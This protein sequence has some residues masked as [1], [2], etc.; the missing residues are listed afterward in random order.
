MSPSTILP[1]DWAPMFRA[2]TAANAQY[3]FHTVAGR[4]VILSFLGS[5]GEP[6]MAQAA[7]HVRERHRAWLD[8]EHASFFAVSADPADESEHRL[9]DALPGIRVFW[10]FDGAVS[11][12]YGRVGEGAAGKTLRYA[13]QTFV[14]DPMLRVLAAIPIDAAHD[15]R[16]DAVIAGLPAVPAHAGV[17][18]TA[19]VLMLPRIFEVDFCRRLIALYE[20][21]GGHVS[22]FMRDVEGQTRLLHDPRHKKR[23]DFVVED[24]ATQQQIRARLTRRL[25]P[26][27]ANAF[28]FAATRVERYLVACYEEAD[29]GFFGRHRDNTTKGTAHRRFAVTIN[30]NAEDHDGG[31]LVFP[32]F[33]PK[34]YKPPTGGAVVFSCS[35][36]HEARPVT[37][38]RRFAFLPFLYD[39]AAAQIRA[40]NRQ[41][42]APRDDAETDANPST[43]VNN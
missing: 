11:R 33:G 6:A 37:R 2:R 28:Q 34:T 29:R 15:A 14:L 43:N 32:E 40:Q 9:A 19:P 17:A 16:L 7:A 4:Y 22:G 13:P 35:L 18:L 5:L 21:D 10:D 27:L 20:T 25:V 8:D 12:L 23:R 42:V 24:E 31:E 30:L 38:G 36:L 39:N 41:F 26:G 1:G 3:A